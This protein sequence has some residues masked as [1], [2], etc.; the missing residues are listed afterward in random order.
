MNRRAFLGASALGLAGSAAAVSKD[1]NQYF[2]LRSYQL[3]FSKSNQPERLAEFLEKHHLP[4]TKRVGIEAVGYFQIHL[5]PDMPRIVTVTAYG[6]LADLEAKRAARK[7]DETWSKAAQ[8]FGTAGDPPFVRVESWLLRAFDGMPKLE[9]PPQKAGQP[10]RLFDLRTYEAETFPDVAE[11][12][13]MFDA[14]EIVIF[15]RAGI[16]PV[17]FGETLFGSKMPSLTY[18]V[19]YDDM[20]A[21]AAAW[22]KFLADPDW[23]RISTKPGWSNADIVS[24][25][26]NIFLTPLPFSPIR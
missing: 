5:G 25:I 9:V 18:M 16:N 15:R 23:K 14:E 22:S 13:R 6:S 19:W 3:R 20:N 12:I 10:T 1:M 21:R 26:S 24:N 8:A 2:E 11:K 7:G 17:F 4:M